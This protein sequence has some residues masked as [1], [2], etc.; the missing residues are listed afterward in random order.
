MAGK[1]AVVCS[2][3]PGSK[4]AG[5]NV[6][7]SQYGYGYDEEKPFHDCSP[8]IASCM[9][10]QVT[11]WFIMLLLL[12]GVNAWIDDQFCWYFLAG[13]TL[14]FAW[15]NFFFSGFVAGLFLYHYF[16]SLIP[17]LRFQSWKDMGMPVTS[18]LSRQNFCIEIWQRSVCLP[19]PLLI[20]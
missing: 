11:L 9:F 2:E 16:N 4:S 5:T 1:W 10:F 6:L 15:V 13:Q 20:F 7:W 12:R 19:S 8:G 17:Q 18:C 3:R 14:T